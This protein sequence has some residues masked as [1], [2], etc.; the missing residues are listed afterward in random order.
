MMF[1]VSII[2]THLEILIFIYTQILIFVNLS[3]IYTYLQI[4]IFALTA[5]G[6][7]SANVY[8]SLVFTEFLQLVFFGQLYTRLHK[9]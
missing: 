6:N 1:V 5:G 4:L 9:Y 8:T 3:I 7:K 2:Y